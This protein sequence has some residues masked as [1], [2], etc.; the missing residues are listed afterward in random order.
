MFLYISFFESPNHSEG[1]FASPSP[2]ACHRATARGRRSGAQC[3]GTRYD[4]FIWALLLYFLPC[5][6]GCPTPQEASSGVGRLR[7]IIGTRGQ[8]YILASRLMWKACK[9]HW[10]ADKPQWLEKLPKCFSNIV[11]AFLIHKK[12]ICKSVMDELRCS[13]KSPEDIYCIYSVYLF[14]PVGLIVFV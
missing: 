2:P 9:R 12:A 13:G 11:P 7:V 10:H 14:E 3:V 5:L 1:P 8:Y 4:T 6:H